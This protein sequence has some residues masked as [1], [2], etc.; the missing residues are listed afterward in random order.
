MAAIIE[1]ERLTNGEGGSRGRKHRLPLLAHPERGRA[2]G[3]P[4]EPPLD[5]RITHAPTQPNALPVRPHARDSASQR[6]PQ[7]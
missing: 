6:L 4:V 5:R 2:L 3:I 1:S 7:A